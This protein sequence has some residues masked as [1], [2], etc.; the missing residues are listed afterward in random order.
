MTEPTMRNLFVFIDRVLALGY[1]Y[2]LLIGATRHGIRMLFDDP[3][4]PL[5]VPDRTSIGNCR[6][7]RM[8]W[9][10]NSPTSEPMDLLFC[11]HRTGGEDGTPPPGAVNFGP[12]D[13]R[14][15]SPNLAVHG[16]ESD[17][18]GRQP[19]LSA[20]AAKRITRLSTK[21]SVSSMRKTGPRVR[22]GP[23]DVDEPEPDSNHSTATK[24]VRALDSGFTPSSSKQPS[25]SP[26]DLGI[27][28]LRSGRQIGR[29]TD[30]EEVF[31]LSTRTAVNSGGKRD[32]AAMAEANAA[33]GLADSAEPLR[34]VAR[35]LPIFDSGIEGEPD[36]LHGEVNRSRQPTAPPSPPSSPPPLAHHPSHDLAS[37][38]SVQ[39]QLST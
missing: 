15:Q 23:A 17:S 24:V 9:S 11:G 35:G 30:L 39:L 25:A 26:T 4:E 32:L 36:R 2:H 8:W 27:R 18:D 20:T 7:V 22:S 14:G 13:H 33:N 37:A 38:A 12:R 6:Y 16:D 1:R 5:R 10:M 21:K 3:K 28:V 31:R 34:K 19:E 29:E